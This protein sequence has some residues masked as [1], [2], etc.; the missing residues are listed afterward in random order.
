MK[1]IIWISLL[2][3][4]LMEANAQKT[5]VVLE[6]SETLSFDKAQASRFRC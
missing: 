1:H 2:C 3:F 4:F 6:N 5:N